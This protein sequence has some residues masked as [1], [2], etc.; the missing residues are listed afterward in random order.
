[1]IYELFCFKLY[2]IVLIISWILVSVEYKFD[3]QRHL[4]SIPCG[5]SSESACGHRW[6][7]QWQT[8]VNMVKHGQQDWKVCFV[9]NHE[10]QVP[11]VSRLRNTALLKKWFSIIKCWFSIIKCWSALLKCQFCIARMLECECYAPLRVFIKKNPKKISQKIF[12]KNFSKKI[13]IFFSKLCLN[14]YACNRGS[15]CEILGGLGPLV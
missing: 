7:A 1:M 10:I 15:A 8:V 9:K 3:P 4:W 2:S 5:G 6:L 12:Q 11:F 14:S 13:P